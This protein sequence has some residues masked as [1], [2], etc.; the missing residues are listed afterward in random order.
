VYFRSN[1]G[2]RKLPDVVVDLRGQF[3]VT[4]VGFVTNS[5][6]AGIRTTF[7]T[8]PDTPVTKFVLRLKGGKQG[9]LQNS[10]NLCA[11]PRY[12]S[13]RLKGQNGKATST[14]TRIQTDCKKK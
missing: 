9:L 4:L 1:G 14:K 5:K 8:A 6:H 2:E 10:E 3:H 7:A 11:K 12:A 13:V